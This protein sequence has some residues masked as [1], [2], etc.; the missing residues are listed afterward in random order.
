MDTAISGFK[1]HSDFIA[2]DEDEDDQD[3]EISDRYLAERLQVV[4]KQN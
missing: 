2:S 3:G 1:H 4:Q